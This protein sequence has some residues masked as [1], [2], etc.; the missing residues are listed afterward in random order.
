[1][2]NGY[3]RRKKRKHLGGHK[4]KTARRRHLSGHHKKRRRRRG[5]S[6]AGSSHRVL[7]GKVAKVC[8][9]G[10]GPRSKK[11][12]CMKIGLTK[13]LEAAKRFAHK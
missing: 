6:G 4:R 10:K 13:G 5:L 8:L 9:V 12:K 2:L 11:S 1:M 7:F 3:H